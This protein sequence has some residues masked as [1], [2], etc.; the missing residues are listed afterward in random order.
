MPNQFAWNTMKIIQINN[1]HSIARSS[2]T[3]TVFAALSPIVGVMLEMVMAWRFGS[4]DIVDAYRIASLILA[5]GSQL[6]VSQMLPHVVIPLFSEYRAKKSDQEGWQMAFTLATVFSAMSLVLT[7]FIWIYPDK[8]VDF[9]GPGLVGSSREDALTLV[10]YFGLTFVINVWSGVISGILYCYRVFWIPP[11]TQLLFNLFLIFVIVLLGSSRGSTSLTL[12][13]LLGSTTMFG[14]YLYAL[15]QVANESRIHFFSCFKFGLWKDVLRALYLSIPLI[16]M[17][18]VGQ[19]GV[20]VI[21]RYLSEMP[22]GSLANFGYAWKMIMFV[23]LL[24]ASLATVIFPTLSDALARNN[25][26][27]LSRLVTKTIK[28]TLFLTLPLALVLFVEQLPVISFMFERGAMSSRDVAETAQLFGLL[29]IG[30]PAGALW[31]VLNK[32]AFAMLDQKSPLVIT[33]IIAI[34][35]T[36][37]VP[38]AAKYYGANGVAMI[39]SLMSLAGTLLLL[40]YQIY[41]FRVVQ[42]SDIVLYFGKLAVLCIGIALPVLLIRYFFY[43][44]D[45][46]GITLLATELVTVNVVT[47]VSVFWLSRLLGISEMDELRRFMLNQFCKLPYI[48]RFS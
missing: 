7:F 19:W 25:H 24:P 16:G 37:L 22:I 47:I 30:A 23:G 32:V 12:G 8:F 10:R 42:T 15:L 31:V 41:K 26:D 1:R 13:I 20:I 9:L 34:G 48:K 2:F 38:Y 18:I 17:I 14:V 21:N 3:L 45:V 6:F 43:A 27:E 28:M 44:K 5:I 4:A 36:L 35:I 11:V 46:T 29:V 40:S 39:Y 33:L